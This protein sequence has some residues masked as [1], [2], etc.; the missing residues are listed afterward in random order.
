MG[1]F[2]RILGPLPCAPVTRCFSR[3]RNF[4][5]NRKERPSGFVI[6]LGSSGGRFCL[7]WIVRIVIPAA[8]TVCAMGC[9][10]GI[11]SAGERRAIG[12]TQFA[13]QPSKRKPAGFHDTKGWMVENIQMKLPVVTLSSSLSKSGEVEERFLTPLGALNVRSRRI[14][15]GGERSAQIE[16]RVDG[17]TMVYW[18]AYISKIDSFR[19]ALLDFI[20][21]VTGGAVYMDKGRRT[22][23]V[24]IRV[25]EDPVIKIQMSV[26]PQNT[27][28]PE[29]PE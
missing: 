4:H 6:Q 2:R 12:G 10:M 15:G 16:I 17:D 25:E 19:T 24:T 8:A 27:D 21:E 23:D 13:F 3:Y 22:R 11:D 7:D 14:E 18:A 20:D 26:C 5:F 1:A 9:A 29:P 28:S